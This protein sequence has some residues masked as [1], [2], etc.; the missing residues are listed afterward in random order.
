MK[1]TR[2]E[3]TISEQASVLGMLTVVYC[4]AASA[5]DVAIECDRCEVDM[6]RT[7]HVR[8][9]VTD[10]AGKP[11]AGCRLLPY[12][13]GK[14]WGAHEVAD[15]T[16][17]MFMPIPLPNPGTARIQVQASP[18]REQANWLWSEQTGENQTVYFEKTFAVDGKPRSALLRAAVDNTCEI[19]LNGHDIGKTSG[20]D[21]PLLVEGIE[22][23]L[24]TG[25]NVLR[26]TAHNG[27]GPAG[28]VVELVMETSAGRERVLSDSSWRCRCRGRPEGPLEDVKVIG[29]VDE[30]VCWLNIGEYWPGVIQRDQLF[31]G[32]PVPED[33]ILSNTAEVTVKKR[34]I[35]VFEEPDHL[36]GIQWEPW[37]TPL[38]AYWQTAHAVP[39]IGYYEST[40]PDVIRQHALWLMDAGIN[41]VLADWSNHIW[42]KKHWHERG[43]GPNEIIDA[44]TTTL[45]QYASMRDE[46]LPVP[47]MIIMPGLSNGPPTTME[48][49]NE[50][51]AWLKEEYIDNPRFEGLWV[52]YEG[53]PLVVPL[54]CAYLAAKEETPPVDTSC[55]TVRWMGTQLQRTHG[56]EH[57]YWSWMD[58]CLEPIV[59]YY[60]GEPEVVTPT[61]AYFGHGGWLYPEARGRCGGT[62]YIESFKTALEHRPRFVMLHQWNE[63]AGQPEGHGYGEKRDIYVDSYSVELS[64]DLEPVSLTADGY[65]DDSGG[66]GYY[67]LNLTQALISLFHQE[68]PADTVMAVYPPNRGQTV[69]DDRLEVGWAIA[70]KMPTGYS[71]ELDGRTVKRVG[72]GETSFTV[73][74][75][76]VNDG[77][78][79]L[80]VVAEGTL[81]RFELSYTEMD[82]PVGD[83]IPVRVEVPFVVDSSGSGRRD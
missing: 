65:R 30:V 83:P 51:L 27:G 57:G 37:F 33:A 36:I 10:E 11:V 3:F 75:T 5:V 55:F 2:R 29:P 32:R 18:R 66:W 52:I 54:D 71:I 82:K 40:N 1:R 14:R 38:N 64:D 31:A 62:T 12:V 16:G 61:P 35:E 45:E 13:N 50:A 7:V 25:E 15:A 34:D 58:G 63:F 23:R 21:K 28:L 60:K 67:Y 20:W 9:E 72:P 53:K 44:T 24:Q 70:G 76:D 81:T 73:D 6:G 8:A 42:G 46:G 77:N 56:D 26:V 17:R 39:V 79:T 59:T 69:N 41:F 74:L 4:T 43:K 47:K 49:I 78:H 80:A 22:E 68:E 19:K 48:A